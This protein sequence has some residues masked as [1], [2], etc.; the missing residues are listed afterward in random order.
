MYFSK[1]RVIDPLVLGELD[2]FKC[3]KAEGFLDEGL[4][5]FFR[6]LFFS[7]NFL[8]Q[9]LIILN[10]LMFYKRRTYTNILKKKTQI[11]FFKNYYSF[12]IG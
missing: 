11:L 4:D 1:A 5:L 9:N 10:L 3:L 12:H 6:N 8:N 7:I 2:P